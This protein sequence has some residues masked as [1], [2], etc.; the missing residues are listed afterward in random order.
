MAAFQFQH[1]PTEK[2]EILEYFGQN[3]AQYRAF[4]LP[5]H[6]G[7]DI[8]ASL[9]SNVV[10]VAAGTVSR[11]VL[12]Q[13]DA[14]FERYGNH[15]RI[16]H[17]DGYAT[18]YAHLNDVTLNEGEQVEAGDVIGAAGTS[19][20]ATYPHLKLV[21]HHQD[22]AVPGYPDDIINPMPFLLPLL[23]WE[24]P[25]PPLL[26]GWA[27]RP[28][29][30][31]YDDLAQVSAGGTILRSAPSLT[32][33]DLGLIPTG[34]ILRV[35][36]LFRGRF[37]PVEMHTEEVQERF[38]VFVPFVTRARSERDSDEGDSAELGPLGFA[39]RSSVEM[40]D[41]WALT[42]RMSINGNV[43]TVKSGG[44]TVFEAAT[45]FSDRLGI[46]AANEQVVVTGSAVRGFTPIR[47]PRSKLQPLPPSPEPITQGWAPTG[48]LIIDGQT[49]T[50]RAGGI[51]L[52]TEPER[53]SRRKG[54]IKAGVSVKVLGAAFEVFTPISVADDD[55]QP[56][57]ETPSDVRTG[58]VPTGGIW[59]QE[60]VATAK[61]G[62]VTMRVAADNNAT[63]V[64]FIP[65]NGQM[66]ITGNASGFFT[67]VSVR[68][69]VLRSITP[70]APNPVPPP[71]IVGP[72][73][74]G[75][76][77][78]ADP[79]IT[80]A[81][82]AEFRSARVSMI[83][84]LSFHSREAVQRLAWE[85]QTASWVVRAFLEFRQNNQIRD[86]S[87]QRFFNDTVNDV[88]RTLNALPGK[89]V[90]VE[91]HNEPNLTTEG[92]VLSGSYNWS[93]GTRFAAWWFEV[94]RLY[95]QRFPN[96]RFIFPGL[97]PGHTIAGLRQ[98]H[99]SFIE[100]ARW[101]VQ[102]ADGLGIHVYWS[103]HYPLW[104]ALNVVD[105]YITRFPNLPIYV[106][107]ASNNG[108]GRTFPHKASE[109]I[110]FWE[111]LKLRPTVR[112]VTYFVASASD[113]QFADEVWVGNGI[114]GIVGRR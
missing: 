89:D 43:G 41:G 22:H 87:P 26:S 25:K 47:V 15:I 77:A 59:I 56:P 65:A 91:L 106:T 94:L 3:P 86:I 51:T 52:F 9:D 93:N 44:I 30:T 63:A 60:R 27:Y 32:S 76:H 84:V 75:L 79:L 8:A 109:Y 64:G 38:Q 53:N 58:W 111:E 57:Y 12:E 33:D 61:A 7:V 102:S 17:D 50:T 83:K 54:F 35:T 113:P 67:P 16:A 10:A 37:A 104:Q 6:D 11:V 55:L 100:Q 112:G 66:N 97:S 13:D 70:V 80:T 69:D 21:L 23:G 103:I 110:H 28:S 48:G 82:F 73:R 72:A 90:V 34:T 85:N 19:G 96:A 14:S 78:S 107:E 2:Q 114:G 62:G 20:D 71:P 101:A 4:G 42:H 5:G 88:A 36:G 108:S 105:D 18:T 92:M 81:E 39:G 99:V 49:A 40:V 68:T 1:W 29:L 45:G 95:R 98:D 46:V 24:R 31:I 74:L